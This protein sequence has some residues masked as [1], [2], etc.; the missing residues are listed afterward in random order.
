MFRRI[1]SLLMS[2]KSYWRTASFAEMA[3]LY[4]SRFIRIVAQGLIGSFVLI[5][6]YQKGYPVIDLFLILVVYYA[7]RVL[8]SILSAYIVA[9]FGP[10]YTMLL[11]NLTAIPAFVS[12]SMI[13]IYGFESVV[14]FFAFEAVS[15]SLLLIST[16]VQFSSIKNINAAGRELAWMRTAERIAAG[17]SPAIG[18]I[19]A[20]RFTP[21]SV[22]WIAALLIVVSAMP[23]FG[24]AESI[25]NHQRIVFRGLPWKKLWRQFRMAAANGGDITINSSIW[26]LF[27][28]IAIFG[29]QDSRVYMELGFMFS[30]SVFASL[31]IS[32]IYGVLIDSKKGRELFFFG[33]GT[34]ALIHVLRPFVSTPLGAGAMNVANEVGLSAYAMPFIRAQYDVPDSVPGYRVVYFALLAA[35][36][37]LGAMLFIAFGALLVWKFGEVNGMQLMFIAAALMYLF[38]LN[39]GFPSLRVRR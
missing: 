17:I 23:L 7:F 19:L 18:G 38:Y 27:I 26:P 37:Y 24:T 8:M 9:W 30:L 15:L 36:Q 35:F 25:Q 34:S 12:L 10:K 14:G 11:S 5:I 4:A 6:L 39:N 16:D 22:M 13:E 33:V 1:S 29:T 32:R 2:T 20:Y 31:I 28:A 21:E 3:Q